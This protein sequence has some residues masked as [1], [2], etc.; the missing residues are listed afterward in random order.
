MHENK[1]FAKGRICEEE[2]VRCPR[3]N[4]E[5]WVP[6][7]YIGNK[8]KPMPRY[9]FRGVQA[10]QYT[11]PYFLHILLKSGGVLEQITDGVVSK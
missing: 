4:K 10:L 1:G 9:G 7:S 2:G 5:H 3:K 8:K 11:P 6:F